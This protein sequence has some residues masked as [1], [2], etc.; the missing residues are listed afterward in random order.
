LES[1]PASSRERRRDRNLAHILDVAR[2]LALE[3]GPDALSL[4]EVARHADYSP[5]ALYRYFPNKHELIAAL[6][7]EAAEVLGRRIEAVP[8]DLPPRARLV[9]LAEAYVAFAEDDPQQFALFER[10]RLPASPWERYLTLAW[11]FTVI[12]DAVAEAMAS[13][14]IAEGDAPTAALGLWALAH[15]FASLRAGHLHHVD[16]DHVSM[17]TAAFATYVRG[18]REGDAL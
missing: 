7:Q 11:P 15:G 3:H 8:V 2:A 12:V 16:A 10:L 4:R 1:A 5:A 6:G 9:E 13:G 14:A 17:R 18:L